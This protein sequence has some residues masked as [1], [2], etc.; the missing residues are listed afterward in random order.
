VDILPTI[1]DYLGIDP[2][3]TAQGESL[4]GLVE[5][6][7][8]RSKHA[9]LSQDSINQTRYGL[10]T[11]DVKLVM[12]LKWSRRELYDLR[13]DPKEQI[14]VSAERA[15]LA[16]ELERRLKRLVAAN[17]RLHEA[18]ATGGGVEGDV[19][20]NEERKRLEALGYVN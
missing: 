16:D 19:L 5:G 18:F 3:E 14:D 6:P 1:L 8:G 17:R 13:Q 15:E 20:S 4:L 9:V 10:R 2:P 7:E 11:D 12:D